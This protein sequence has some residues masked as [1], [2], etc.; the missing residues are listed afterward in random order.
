M[1]G[2]PI[3][4]RHT[5]LRRRG[6]TLVELLVVIA[7]ISILAS[8]VLVVLG[9]MNTRAKISTTQARISLIASALDRYVNDFDD[10]PPSDATDGKKGAL[11]LYKCLSTEMK[12]GPYIGGVP[13]ADLTGEND[14]VIVDEWRTPIYYFHHKDYHNQP[15]NKHDFR[16]ISLG[17]DRLDQKGTPDSDDIVNWNKAKPEQE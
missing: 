12:N 13:T 6:F 11:S 4:S 15:P 2:M 17:P 8:M 16:L 14:V 3:V 5:V 1:N 10:Y 9:V 7:I